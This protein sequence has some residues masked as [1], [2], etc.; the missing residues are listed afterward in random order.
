MRPTLKD[1]GKVFIKAVRRRR[2][3]AGNVSLR[4]E[5]GWKE[6]RYWRV[7]GI[8]VEAGKIARGRGY[9]GTVHIAA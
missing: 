6:P 7:H 2:G 5:L 4:A 9:G 3:S 8:L 1:D